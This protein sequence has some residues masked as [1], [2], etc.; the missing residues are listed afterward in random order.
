MK[1]SFAITVCN[2]LNEIKQLLPFLI[3]NKEQNDEIV[4]LFDDKNGDRDVINFLLEHKDVSNVKILKSLEFNNDFAEWKNMLNQNCTGD[5]IFQ[6]DADEMISNHLIDN[7][8]EIIELNKEIDLFFIPR[9]NTVKGITEEHVKKWRWNVDKDGRVNFP[10]YQGRIYKSNLKWE[11]KVHE[12]ISGAKYYSL[13]PM[14]EEYSLT[15]HKTISRQEKQN[16]Y[17][18]NIK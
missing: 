9:I 7:L 1:I 10:D 8:H 13:L 17:Y 15:H 3:E 4:V 5:Y 18:E 16:N 12:R 6:L 14:E 2:E 11:G